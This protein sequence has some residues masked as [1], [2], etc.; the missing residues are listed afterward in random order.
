VCRTGYTENWF[1]WNDQFTESCCFSSFSFFI[2]LFC[3]CS[4]HHP[5]ASILFYVYMAF[6]SCLYFLLGS[7]CVEYSG[8]LSYCVCVCVCVGARGCV[9][10]ENCDS[11]NMV[12]WINVIVVLCV[13]YQFNSWF[14]SNV[15]CGIFPTSSS[16][17]SLFWF[18]ESVSYTL[19]CVSYRE[20]VG[21]SI[22]MFL[23]T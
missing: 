2:S 12:V 20:A 1:G 7:D 5:Y 11:V 14:S 18:G 21:V 9:Q 16:T 15:M 3:W 4:F 6:G 19:N 13:C 23:F 22:Y 10:T 17:Y 8:V